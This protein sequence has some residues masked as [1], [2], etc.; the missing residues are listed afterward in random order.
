MEPEYVLAEWAI[1]P[2]SGKLWEKEVEVQMQ[3][4]IFWL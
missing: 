1:R 2:L 4:F 3:R